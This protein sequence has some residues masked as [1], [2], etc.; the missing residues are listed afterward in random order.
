M[1]TSCP[2]CSASFAV[3]Q[4]L[5]GYSVMCPKCMHP[6]WVSTTVA[7]AAGSGKESAESPSTNRWHIL[8]MVLVVSMAFGIA[9]GYVI[10]HQKGNSTNAQKLTDSNARAIQA[11]LSL[12]ER[13]TELAKARSD[14]AK[15]FEQSKNNVAAAYNEKQIAIKEHEKLK[16]IYNI[17]LV[18]LKADSVNKSNEIE[19]L[20]KSYA[21]KIQL[22]ENRH[23]EVEDSHKKVIANRSDR[24]KIK[25][26]EYLLVNQDNSDIQRAGIVL[27]LINYKHS[28][29]E[30]IGLSRMFCTS[31]V[32][33]ECAFLVRLG[34]DFIP[35][36]S[37]F[38]F[39]ESWSAA[40]SELSKK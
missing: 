34:G 5:S 15:E 2:L 35:E 31:D 22:I 33:K 1:L 37:K 40:L 20:T 26:T 19:A 17:D 28:D 21:A 18:N 16:S 8:V 30:A 38:T 27:R 7:E 23:K 4:K 10:G 11:E 3:K 12:S 13:D 32:L 39:S 9:G 29:G 36:G 24:A 6:V 25:L 14:Q